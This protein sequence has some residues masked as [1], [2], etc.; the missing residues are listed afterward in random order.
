M[1]KRGVQPENEEWSAALRPARAQRRPRRWSPVVIGLAVALVAY[2]LVC[3]LVLG[4]ERPAVVQRLLALVFVGL[5]VT[6]YVMATWPPES[7]E[8]ALLRLRRGRHADFGKQLR[9]KQ[10]RH[11]T[12]KL[13]GIGETSYRLWGGGGVVLL[14]AVGWVGAWG[15]VRV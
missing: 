10:Q 13:P 3:L 9:A 6:L 11:R 4:P 15:R 1:A 7:P 12:V 14:C 2:L 5:S 8:D